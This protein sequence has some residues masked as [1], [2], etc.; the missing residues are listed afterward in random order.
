MLFD[1]AMSDE[2]LDRLIEYLEIPEKE[3]STGA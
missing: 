1:C 2:Q 3:I